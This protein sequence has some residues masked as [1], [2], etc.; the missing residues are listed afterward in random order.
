MLK[1]ILSGIIAIVLGVSLVSVPVFAE[2]EEEVKNDGRLGS[3]N[4]IILKSCADAEDG[5][6]CILNFAVDVLSIGV[7]VVGVIGISVAGLQYLTAGGSEE[8]TRKAKTRINEIIIGL[9]IYAVFFLILKW[10]SV[11]PR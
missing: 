3:E 10:L 6:F 11:T 4:A 9:A 5:I 7:G 2:E 8:K 1:K